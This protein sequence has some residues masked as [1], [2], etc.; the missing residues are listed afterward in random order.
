MPPRDL[1]PKRG[2]PAAPLI[3][4]V[5]RELG[6]DDILRLATLPKVRVQPPPIQRIKAVHHRQK[7]NYTEGKTAFHGNLTPSFA[8]ARQISR[9]ATQVGCP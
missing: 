9:A 7:E 1:L 5:V 3:M 8:S 6:H 2:A 4:S